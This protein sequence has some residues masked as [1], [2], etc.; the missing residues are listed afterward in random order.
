MTTKKHQS[1]KP[2]K[3]P[4][5]SRAEQT[6]A[7]ILEAAACILETKGLDGLNTNLVAQRA[8]VSIGSLYQYF[9]GK[10]ALIVALSQR[11][12]AVFFAE[13]E[14]ALNEPTGQRGLKHL[15]AASVRQQLRRPT[16]ARLLDFEENRPSIAKELAPFITAMT[17]LIR[18]LLDHEDIPP[19]PSIETAA[20]DII[21]IVRAIV[22]AAGERGEVDRTALELRVSR[23]L[24]GYLGIVGRQP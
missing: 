22:D 16:L 7:A 19:Q 4:S 23:A 1:L 11:E 3:I 8:G 10:D 15:I 14:G 9:P 13:A 6:V 18:Q 5:Q 17:E 2:R 20:G 24:F 21:A 12:R